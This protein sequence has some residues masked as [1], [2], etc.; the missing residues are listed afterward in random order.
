MA[1]VSGGVV[2]ADRAGQCEINL[3]LSRLASIFTST[4]ADARV[5]HDAYPKLCCCYTV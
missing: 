5:L 3:M 2:S 4:G 1:E